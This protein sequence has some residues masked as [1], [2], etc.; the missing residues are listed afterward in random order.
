MDVTIVI[1]IIIIVLIF[2]YSLVNWSSIHSSFIIQPLHSHHHHTPVTPGIHP[3]SH[4]F[5]HTIITPHSPLI[6]PSSRPEFTLDS[7][8]IHTAVTIDL[9]CIFSYAKAMLTQRER[10][11]TCPSKLWTHLA[12]LVNFTLSHTASPHSVKLSRHAVRIQSAFT[13]H[14]HQ[15]NS[16][17]YTYL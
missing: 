17:F 3:S 1:T 11:L 10:C 4:P 5:S 14:S 7:Y 2:I 8:S 6:R 13:L 16:M 15:R 9:H 12:L